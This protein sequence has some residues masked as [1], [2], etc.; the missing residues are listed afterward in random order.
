MLDLTQ[1]T[2]QHQW[3]HDSG[4][5]RQVLASMLAFSASAGYAKYTLR[6]DDF[7][8]PKYGAIFAI[9]L[10]CMVDGAVDRV[11][12]LNHCRGDQALSEQLSDLSFG[13]GIG[14]LYEE[15]IE[16]ACQAIQNYA[17]LRRT[18]EASLKV[19]ARLLRNEVDSTDAAE[20]INWATSELTDALSAREVVHGGRSVELIVGDIIRDTLDPPSEPGFVKSPV[21]GLNTYLDGGFHNGQQYVIAGRPGS[22][23]TSLAME[24]VVHAALSGK[25][26]VVYSF[27]MKDRRL[28]ER[29]LASRAQINGQL[30]RRPTV[31]REE[32]KAQIINEGMKLAKLP[33]RVVEAA[34]WTI[35]QVVRDVKRDHMRNGIGLICLDYAQRVK[36]KGKRSRE[37]EVA[38]ISGETAELAVKHNFPSLLLA[39]LN[40]EVDKRAEHKPVMGDLRESGALEQDADAIIFTY[41]DGDKSELIIGKNRDGE[42][43]SVPVKFEKQYTRFVDAA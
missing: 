32:Q 38:T 20:L 8:V 30:I 5:E 28:V 17:A 2:T 33:I 3:P 16:A 31:L 9:F 29:I 39:Q 13:V 27:E 42:T 25:R 43:G 23:K 40:R 14:L 35:D 37:E 36:V 10:D 19:A 1:W 6:A 4:L 11:L 21:H 26:V 41:R 24:C 12:V 22:G 18:V 15:R 34:G 7:Y